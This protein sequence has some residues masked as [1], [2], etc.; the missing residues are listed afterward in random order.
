MILWIHIGREF[1]WTDPYFRG[2]IIPFF[3]EEV[4]A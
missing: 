2:F 1:A 4:L 3:P